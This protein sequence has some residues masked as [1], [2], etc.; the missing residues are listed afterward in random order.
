MKASRGYFT[1]V[2]K[3]EV[4]IERL[5]EALEA[6]KEHPT[7]ENGIDVASAVIG[8]LGERDLRSANE[9]IDAGPLTLPN[10]ERQDSWFHRHPWMRGERSAFELLDS[11]SMPIQAKFYWSQK[12]GKVFVAGAV[13]FSKNWEDHDFTR[14]DEFKIGID[15]FLTPDATSLLVVISNKGKLRVLELSERLSNTQ[16]EIFRSWR[17]IW[18]ETSRE[19]L[20]KSLWESFALQSVNAKFYQGVSEAFR[21]LLEHLKAIEKDEEASKL[22]ASRL[23]GRLIFVWFLRKM[24]IVS[25][26]GDYFQCEGIAQDV[27]Y[28]ERLESLFFG[29]LNTPLGDRQLLANGL[30]DDQTPYLNGGLFAP[31]EDDWV[32][33]EN[34]TFPESFFVRLF[35][36]FDNFNFTTDES[37]PEYE[38]IAI[39]PEMLGRVFESLLASQIESTG[40]QARKAKGAFYTPREIVAFMCTETVRGYLESSL[41]N[42]ARVK[43]ATSK[44][45][46]TSDQDW[47]IAGTNSL[48]DIP[49]D[50][51]SH[52]LE[53]LSKVKTVDPACGSGAFPLGILALLS[54]IQLRLD[55]KLDEYELKLAILRDSIY[56]VDI[57]PMAVEISRLRAWLSLIVESKDRQSIEPLPNLDFNFVA[58]NSLVKLREEDLISFNPDLHNKLAELRANYFSATSPTQKQKAQSAYKALTKKDLLDQ[59]DLRAS[60]LKTFDPFNSDSSAEFFDSAAMFGLRDGFDIVLGNP[61]YVDSEYMA[62]HE[63]GLREYIRTNYSSAKGNWDLFV[64]F[65]EHG[66]KIANSR[67]SISYIV[68]NSLL[69]APYAQ[70]VRHLLLDEGL[71]SVRDFGSLRVF[72]SAAVDTCIFIVQKATSCPMV[73][74]H[75]METTDLVS[76]STQA[77]REVMR[78]ASNWVPFFLSPSRQEV[79]EKMKRFPSLAAR[80]IRSTSSAIVSEAYKIAEVVENL[81][82]PGRSYFKL[83][84][85][86]TIDPFRTF[87]GERPTKYLGSVYTHPV[88][89]ADALGEINPTRLGQARLPK[90]VINGMG[91]VEAFWDR[92]G[93][94][95]AGKTTSI[96]FDSETNRPR[97]LCLIHAVMNSSLGRFW[98]RANFLSGG[99]A[100]LN[101]KSLLT[102]PMPEMLAGDEDTLLSLAE[103]CIEDPSSTSSLEAL[104]EFV[105]GVFGVASFEIED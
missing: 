49:V 21:E 51:K 34:L 43:A 67:G 5:G 70:E 29:T 7:L 81:E 66:L 27:Y 50:I 93:E 87:W 102:L 22:F 6:L 15:F 100:G 18:G 11:N 95:L 90:L 42:D 105:L 4:D 45:L 99:M 25:E 63:R 54:R 91:N 92:S 41:P 46:D 75:Q 8:L 33:D 35:S 13:H 1:L 56:G 76:S 65:I 53:V 82:N 23:L 26:K 17:G 47:I 48:R 103:N 98:F 14:S 104:N 72:E 36:H 58:A 20:H 44:L 78:S 2:V 52:F 68:K 96:V 30:L 60:Q 28:K 84:N 97:F 16:I 64:P 40:E 39:D 57:E 31:R 61:P 73:M 32:G 9:V 86:G 79:L 19:L 77:P 12:R 85:T 101:P 88:V 59:F 83:I 55:P 80:G 69:S 62:K 94:F 24:A 74:N 38:Q 71:E 3:F 89:S 10:A 37:T